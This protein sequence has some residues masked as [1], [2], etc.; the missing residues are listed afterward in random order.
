MLNVHLYYAKLNKELLPFYLP[1]GVLQNYHNFLL[2]LVPTKV[3]NKW[4]DRMLSIQ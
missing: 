2:K 3:I 4:A 1:N